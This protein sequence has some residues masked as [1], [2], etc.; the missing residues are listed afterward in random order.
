MGKIELIPVE[1]MPLVKRDDDIA[2]LIVEAL[3]N[4]G[5]K[6]LSKDILVIAQKIVSKAE[7]R[8]VDLRELE[9]SAEAVLLA[10]K[11]GKEP[12]LVEAI[13]RESNEILRHS[14]GLIIAEQKLGIVC[15]NAGID[16]SNVAG[17]GGL[18]ALLPANP[19]ESA[20]RIRMRIKAL[21]DKEVAVIIND[22]HG[23]PFRLG[24]V[25][26]AIGVAG[27]RPISDLR[28][29]KDLCSYTMRTT[30]AA[31]ADELASA[32]SIL[33]GQCDEAIPAVVVRGLDYEPAPGSAR[34]LIRNPEKDLFR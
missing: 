18:V 31:L 9:V 34:Q 32:A 2:W 28:G 30:T 12:A 5:V 6:L 16:Q 23:R 17:G 25:G 15:A 14:D 1:G 33:M 3:G 27:M 24:A 20:G 4:S 22:T 10:E 29:R 21:T 26:I 13:L 8:I 7:G 19:D 11:T